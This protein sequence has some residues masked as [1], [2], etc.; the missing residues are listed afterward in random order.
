[1]KRK[2]LLISAVFGT[3]L[4]AAPAATAQSNWPVFSGKSKSGQAMVVDPS[5]GVL[6]MAPLL[7]KTTPA[8]VNISVSSTV[9]LP[10]T[11]FAD[12]EFFERF[13]GD[14]IPGF[15]ERDNEEDESNE[16]TTQSAG[17]GVIINAG[18]GYVLTNHHVV[19]KADKIT[20]TL[21]DRRTAE[22]ELIGSDP[23]IDIALLK[24]DLNNLTDIPMANS[25]RT[26]VGDFVIAIG[27]PFGIGQTVTSGIVSAL[28]RS[29]NAP[30]KYQNFIQTDAAINRGNSGGALINSKGELIG[31]NAAILSRSGGSNGIG[32]AVPTNMVTGV[33]DQ[34]I[35]YG[36]VRRGR[37]G[38][39]I[40]NITPELMTAMGL[41]SQDGA[42][43]SQV[44][45]DSPAEEAGI[46]EGDVIVEFNGKPILD[47]DDIRN[48]VGYVERGRNA[49]ISYIRDGKKY[50]TKIKVEKAPEDEVV[51]ADDDEDTDVEPSRYEAFDGATFSDIPANMD[52]RGGDDGVLITNVKRGSDAFDAGLRKGDIIRAVN[53]KEIIDLDDFKSKIA[54]KRKA[55]ALTV[56]RGRN[57]IYI[58]VK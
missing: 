21:K 51:Y 47:S 33:M 6:T 15:G 45:E 46:R 41:D 36:E 23:G 58:A 56:Q 35:A 52:P 20:V 7:E 27:N 44:V 43:V 49:D 48:A 57:Q 16:R 13:F 11:P 40:Q 2:T 42:L 10:Q 1:M 28:D 53:N 12:D 50:T 32:F 3:A 22:A 9:K 17:S 14:R 30:D 39:T 25:D 24:I 5:R 18:K 4:V 38:V 31:I 8:V 54:G 37:I 26:K 29:T 55:V 34:L 19:D